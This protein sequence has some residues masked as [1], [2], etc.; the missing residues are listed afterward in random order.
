MD[1]KKLREKLMKKTQSEIAENLAGAEVH[2]IKA[3]KLITDLDAV[4]NLLKENVVDWEKRNPGENAEKM[5]NQLKTNQES[6]DKEKQELTDFI[7]KEM[8][9]ELPVFVSV[10]GAILGAKILAQAG[11]KKRLAFLPASTIQL[12]GAEK[13]LF[14]HLKKKGLCPKHGHLFNHPLIQKLPKQ[15]RGKAAR[16]L[17]GKL[18]I[19]AKM[20]YFGSTT[21][22]DL[23]SDA[24][25]KIAKL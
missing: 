11:S 14:N 25:K 2:I 12:L 9:E 18:A 15:K 19:A 17:A 1:R 23:L 7:E 22:I 5:L 24:E 20:D 16:V 4:S 10:A 8:K 3:V 21:A 13:A 6:I